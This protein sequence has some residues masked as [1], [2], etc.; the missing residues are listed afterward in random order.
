MSDRVIDTVNDTGGNDCVEI[1]GRPVGFARW[2]RKVSRSNDASVTANRAT[3]LV[4][5]LQDRLQMRVGDRAIDEQRLRRTADTRPPHLGVDHDRLGHLEI[6]PGVDIDV[7]DALQM[8]E[9][10]HRC[11]ALNPSDE[12]L[13]ATGYDHVDRSVE[14]TQHVSDC[15][16]ILG[17]HTL[18]RV[19]GQS[20]G[21][22]AFAKTIGN[23]RRRALRFRTAAK[24]HGV[25]GLDAER[26]RI[27]RNVWPA[28]V[29]HADHAERRPHP[30]DLEPVGPIPG[31]DH[32]A[33]RVIESSDLLNANGH[34]LDPRRVERQPISECTGDT[35]A[36]GDREIL[37]IGRKDRRSVGPQG[38][39]HAAQR[40]VLLRG[41]R[42]R[43]RPGR[44]TR[45]PAE[46]HHRCR[47]VVA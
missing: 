37:G 35:L 22:E 30:F 5:R 31:R 16:T 23:R 34:R 43:Q 7:A 24:D 26:P 18:N 29:D 1:L 28:F 46:R 2:R 47:K 13:A 19:L 33:D 41:R 12:A 32:R 4:E 27:G 6:G 9:H 40:F 21:P 10:R 25:A 3:R 39:R 14:T 38:G 11:F 15:V 44:Q 17:R 42:H 8:R 45:V 36:V 20:G